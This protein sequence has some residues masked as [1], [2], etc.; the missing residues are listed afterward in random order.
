MYIS[1]FVE[2]GS[3]PLDALYAG[4]YPYPDVFVNYAGTSS[5]L[6]V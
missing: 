3:I 5:T 4:T 1:G 6:D 2:I